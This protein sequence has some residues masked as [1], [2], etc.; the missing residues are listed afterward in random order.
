[1]FGLV[2][3]LSWKILSYIYVNVYLFRF[4][5]AYILSVLSPVKI[6]QNFD[7]FLLSI[8]LYMSI[9]TLRVLQSIE[10]AALST[11]GVCA[12]WKW[13]TYASRQALYGFFLRNRINLCYFW[14]QGVKLSCYLFC[15]VDLLLSTC[16]WCNLLGCKVNLVFCSFLTKKGLICS[17]MCVFNISWIMRL[18]ESNERESILS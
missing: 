7:F 14:L 11:C 13:P 15:C 5:P 9:I 2:I 3:T 1:M 12:D 18:R 4:V 6:L 17:P 8:K 16:A 10:V